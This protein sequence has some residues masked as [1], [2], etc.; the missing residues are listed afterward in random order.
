M[1]GRTRILIVLGGAFVFGGG[2]Q[3]LASRPGLEWAVRASGVSAPWLFVPFLAGMTQVER[4]RAGWL[5]LAATFAAL[6]G[7]FAMTWS[8]LEGVSLVHVRQA[9]LA[10]RHLHVTV[11]TYGPLQLPWHVVRLIGPQTP[12]VLGGIAT[13]PL[14]G[15]LGSEWRLCRTWRSALAIAGAFCLEPVAIIVFHATLFW[16]PMLGSFGA[17]YSFNTAAA[18]EV[19]F[20]LLLAIGAAYSI[21][22]RR[23]AWRP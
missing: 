5:G 15:L 18:A 4:R 3:Y 23:T 7:Y 14:F 16:I 6:T 10:G 2:I 13:G 12:W 1:R 8:P 22:R 11:I 20:G 19:G 9:T 17:G 21:M